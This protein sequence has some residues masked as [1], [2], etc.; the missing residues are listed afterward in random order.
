MQEGSDHVDNG[1]LLGDEAAT[2]VGQI[3][4]LVFDVN[5]CNQELAISIDIASKATQMI[6]E[7]MD[8]VASNVSSN[9]EQ[10]QQVLDY[11]DQVSEQAKEL[12]TMTAK[13]K[14]E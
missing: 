11:V 12:L 4:G 2:A 10:S 8:Q 3:K 14:C 5:E 6:A 1:K 13:F 9:K 7:N